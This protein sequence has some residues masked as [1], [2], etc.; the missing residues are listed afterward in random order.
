ME[1]KIDLETPAQTNKK[2]ACMVFLPE[3][4]SE[5]KWSD[6]SKVNQVAKWQA[7]RANVMR[8]CFFLTQSSALSFLLPANRNS[9]KLDH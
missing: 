7:Q 4:L 3:K 2:A 5:A 1:T 8:S 9:C 6:Q